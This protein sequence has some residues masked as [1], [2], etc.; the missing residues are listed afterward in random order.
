M[1]RRNKPKKAQQAHRATIFDKNFKPECYG[2]AF[3]GRDFTCL[4]SDGECLK[5]S[6]KKTPGRGAESAPLLGHATWEGE[7]APSE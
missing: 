6:L 3:A 2:C 5:K 4:S 1:P 7:L